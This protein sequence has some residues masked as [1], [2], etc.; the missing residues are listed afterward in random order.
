M[1]RSFK[2]KK[3]SPLEVLARTR[4]LEREQLLLVTQPTA[5][6]DAPVSIQQGSITVLIDAYWDSTKRAGLAL[7]TYDQ[8]GRLQEV[9]G[10]HTTANDALHAEAEAL[11][12]AL[13]QCTGTGSVI[14][15]Y[16][17]FS[18]CKLLVQAVLREQPEHLPSWMAQETVVRCI[19][20]HK[21]CRGKVLIEHVTRMK[22]KAP[23]YICNKARREGTNF[24]GRPPDGVTEFMQVPAVLNPNHFRFEIGTGT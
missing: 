1:K 18:D 12:A 19:L 23:H 10:L 14:E 20:R 22:L 7:I 16:T 6:R 21:E 2:Q 15:R 8:T 5:W 3:T 13:Q 11:L 9:Q 17:I 4:L 24:R